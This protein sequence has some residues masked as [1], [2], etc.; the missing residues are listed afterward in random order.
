[1]SQFVPSNWIEIDSVQDVLADIN[2]WGTAPVEWRG[3]L[4][5][6]INKDNPTEVMETISVLIGQ[7][8]DV[9][10]MIESGT[11]IPKV[12]DFFY[13]KKTTAYHID[14]TSTKATSQGKVYVC[15]ADDQ[16]IFY[17]A[18]EVTEHDFNGTNT[19]GI[20]IPEDTATYFFILMGDAI[21][22]TITS[23]A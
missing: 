15:K 8:N 17:T 6:T 2:S 21:D 10:D 14:F 20:D 18:T 3:P 22:T 7:T 23:H 11:I 9:A 1:M 4:F 19:I 16:G 12:K 13:C 5:T